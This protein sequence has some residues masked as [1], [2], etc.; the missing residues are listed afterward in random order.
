MPTTTLRTPRSVSPRLKTPKPLGIGQPKCDRMG[1]G[2]TLR[3][4]IAGGLAT[5]MVD[6]E[7]YEVDIGLEE[8]LGA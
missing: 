8:A 5:N 6:V 7:H 3:D 2:R 4:E 1:G